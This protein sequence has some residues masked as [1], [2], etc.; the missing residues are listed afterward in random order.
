VLLFSVLLGFFFVVAEV[1]LLWFFIG[2]IVGSMPALWKQ[3]GK[4]GRT[5]GH[6]ITLGMSLIISFGFLYWIYRTVEGNFPLNLYTWLMS[7]GIIGVGT[8]IP[9]FSSANIL[10]VLGVYEGVL[11]GI[12]NFDLTVIL[13]LVISAI[14]VV[15]TLSKFIAWVLNKAYG[16][17]FHSIL[18]LVVASTLLIVPLD[19]EYLSITGVICLGASVVGLIVARFLV[20]LEEKTKIS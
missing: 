14:I 13:P 5:Q 6:F 17:F 7:G 16:F 4:Q 2:L 8:F 15:F 3:A 10:L 19:V 18:G 1:P 11:Y 20:Q 9:G 12:A